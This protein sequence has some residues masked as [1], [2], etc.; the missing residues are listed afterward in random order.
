VNSL[1][2]DPRRTVQP[3]S[4]PLVL[5]GR[6]CFLRGGS[7]L[8]GR[9]LLSP[10]GF[11]LFSPPS[12]GAFQL[13]LTVLVRY[14]SRDV[15]RVG[16]R[17]LPA[18]RRISDRRYSGTPQELG[19]LRLRGFHPLR[20]RVP[21]DFGFAPRAPTRAL[22][23]H[24]PRTFRPGV[25]FALCRFRSPLLTASLL[26]SFPAGTKMFQFPAFPLPTGSAAK[27]AGGPIRESPV[28][29]LPAPR[30]GLSQLAT[31]FVGAPSR[32]IH[33]AA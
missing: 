23:H 12:R 14:R 22:Q 2:R 18:S 15:F 20:R 29:R 6:P 31:P 21:A 16:S 11:R 3:R 7:T 10:P 9:T 4:P 28:R 26:L 30:R 32:A 13:S 19:G 24:I 25:Q 17:C 33:Q 5:H 8:S 27:A 1:P